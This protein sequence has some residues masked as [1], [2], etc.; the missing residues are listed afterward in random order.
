MNNPL[1]QLSSIL[2]DAGET[3]R[4][5]TQLPWG[6]GS[7]LAREL[8]ADLELHLARLKR[9]AERL[10]PE[11]AEIPPHDWSEPAQPPL[12]L[13]HPSPRPRPQTLDPRQTMRIVSE[14]YQRSNRELQHRKAG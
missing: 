8:L 9:E 14:F 6:P 12:K 3:I 2:I 4:R 1:S 10:S 11:P 13:S 7:A 5:L